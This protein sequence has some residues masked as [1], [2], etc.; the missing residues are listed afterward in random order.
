MTNPRILIAC[1]G[2]IFLGDDG[3]GTEVALRLAGRLLPPGVVL[4]DFGICGL[5]LTYALLEQWDLVILVDACARGGEP[6]TV[7]LIE[8]DQVETAAQGAPAA[9][10][11]THG[12]N[13]MSVLRAAK[14]MGGARSRILLVGCEPADLGSDEEG[15]LGLS[16]PVEAAVDEAVSMIETL[17]SKALTGE[18]TEAVLQLH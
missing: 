12:M 14:L 11:E 2:N 6:G 16:A 5:D 3:F 4:K 13:P 15:K 10:V 9:C 1:V 8:P 17:I 18:L 7:Y